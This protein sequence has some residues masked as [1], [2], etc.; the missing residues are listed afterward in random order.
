MRRLLAAAATVTAATIVACSGNG[1]PAAQGPISELPQQENVLQNPG[2]ED[3]RDPWFSLKP[4]NFILAEDVSHTGQA[5]AL[6][7]I[8][9][10]PEES[11]TKIIYLV[12]E[13]TPAEFPEVISGAFRVTEWVRGTR[14]QYLQF[15]V[16]AFDANNLP[17]G[18]PNHQMRYILTGID[19]EP[20]EIGNAHFVFLSR[21][22][23]PL[24]TWV[25]FQ[26]SVRDDFLNRWGAVPEY[27]KIRLLFEV[28]YDDKAAGEGPVEANVYYDDLYFGPAP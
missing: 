13:V 9:P 23:P 10:E 8:R 7:H 26:V 1:E 22:D 6:L 19:E 12:Q 27:S 15:A 25:P 21:E 4:P 11:G 14:L 18:F 24:D 28:R 2:F 17:G 5:S 20:F 16:I 3:G